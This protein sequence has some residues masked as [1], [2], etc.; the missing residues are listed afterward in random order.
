MSVKKKIWKEERDKERKR[1][2]KI[3]REKKRKGEKQV[4]PSGDSAYRDY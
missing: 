4:W 1:M 2:E 3:K